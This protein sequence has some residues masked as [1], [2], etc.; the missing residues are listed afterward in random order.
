MSSPLTISRIYTFALRAA[1]VVGAVSVLP[2]TV[3]AAEKDLPRPL[4]KAC[5][6]LVHDGQTRVRCVISGDADMERA[7]LELG[8]PVIWDRVITDPGTLKTL[9]T[10]YA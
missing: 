9:Q 2:A 1:L 6:T 4:P 10:E 8:A 7:P 5:Q 3:S